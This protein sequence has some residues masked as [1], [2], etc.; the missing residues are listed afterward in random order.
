[1]SAVKVSL[2]IQ[3]KGVL[4]LSAYLIIAVKIKCKNIGSTKHRNKLNSEKSCTPK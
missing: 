3:E 1:M 4:G 2:Q